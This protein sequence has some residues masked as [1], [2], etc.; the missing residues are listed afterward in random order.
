MFALNATSPGTDPSRKEPTAPSTR[1]L[2]PAPRED[3]RSMLAGEVFGVRV[4]VALAAAFLIA[5]AMVVLVWIVV[6]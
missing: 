1:Y 6:A 5:L 2:D 3:L 4:P